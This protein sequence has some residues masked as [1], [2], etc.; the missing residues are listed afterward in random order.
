M[1]KEELWQAALARLQLNVSRANFAAWFKE[2]TILDW[3]NDNV[4]IGTP[5]SFSKE[6]L[7]KK[8]H[9]DILKALKDEIKINEDETS[10]D[11]LFTLRVT[12]CVGAC[13]LAPVIT[14]GEDV[15]AKINP[16]DVSAILNKYREKE[17]INIGEK[18]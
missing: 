12:R 15:H 1:T 18:T 2:A 11:G 8:F 13:S 16:S 5:N 17:K 10:K 3:Q 6:W 7:K 4:L 14:I 9:E